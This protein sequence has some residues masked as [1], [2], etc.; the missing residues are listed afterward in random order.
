MRKQVYEL[1]LMD[2]RR[3]A[4]WEFA[5]DEEDVEGQD[6]AT[7][8]PHDF[9]GLVDPSAGMMVVRARFRL[10]DGSEHLGYLT[11][12]CGDDVGLG[13]LQPVIVGDGGQVMFWH[14]SMEPARAE[15]DASYLRLGKS[16]SSQV[17][18]VQFQSDVPLAGGPLS[19]E[20]SGFLV[21]ED[22]RSGRTR[23]LR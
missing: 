2:L 16:A 13:A 18:P 20:I 4:A 9:Q 22:W 17:F 10:A 5:L 3:T 23:E 1:T 7:V 14:G 15:M 21:L 6:E 19:G 8:R 11:P 12:P